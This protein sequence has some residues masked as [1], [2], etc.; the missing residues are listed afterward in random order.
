M[1]KRDYYEVL[2]LQRDATENDIK[3]AYR[4]QAMKYHPD[5]NAGD[6]E[7]AARFKEAAEAYEVLGNE[8]KRQVYDQY[9][10][11]GLGGPFQGGGFQWSDFTHAT[12]FEDIFSNLDDVFG[13]G[14]LGD[15]FGRRGGRRGPH[16]GEDLRIPLRLT[17][18]EIA[19]GVQK[20]I[21]IARMDRC[22]T[23]SG[24]GARSGAAARTCS[25]CNGMGQ[26]RQATRSMFGQFVN[27]TTCPQCN[28][29]GKVIGDR[30]PDCGGEGR[31]KKTVSLAV[32]IPAGVTD[33]NYIPLRGQGSVG[34]RD[35]TAGD[36]MVLIEEAEHDHFERHGNDILYELPI[37]FSQAALGA[38]VTVPTLNSRAEMKIP[39]GTQSGQIFR[40]KGK[41][42][43]ELNGY[44]T[45]DQLVRVMVWTPA[46]LNEEEQR[47][48]R[49]IAELENIQPPEGGKGLF[50]RMKEAFGG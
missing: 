47:L 6:E 23:C 42:I 22:G 25:V 4:K 2:G 9:G 3:K 26:V 46:R 34:P 40:L 39:A 37:S 32:N 1:S 17:L 45:G 49:Q 7:A 18:E 28:G 5:R 11:A 50:E 16:R 41:G 10:H 33:G 21:R 27:V 13:G 31:A 19:S 24:S 30:C 20:K 8:R 14:V 29:E 36:C 44:R 15:L 43:P 12:D 48:F 35:G 38:E